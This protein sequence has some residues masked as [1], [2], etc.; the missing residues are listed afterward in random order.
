MVRQVAKASFPTRF[1]KF[2]IYAFVDDEGGEHVALL[3]CSHG[4]HPGLPVRIHSRCLTGDTLASLRCDCRDQLEASLE[5]INGKGCGILVYLD[6]EGRG[7]GLANKIKAYSLQD[8]GMDTVEANQHLGFRDDL[9]D[10]HVAAEI[11]KNLG[12]TEIDLLTNNPQKVE[13]LKLH[14][15][16]VKNR[17]PLVIKPNKYNSRY[18]ETKREK[19]HHMI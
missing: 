15:I 8:E 7:I 3:K 10:Y 9:R 12:V 1:G 19:M 11:L 5:Y 16:T 18:L 13:D 4:I 6:Q 2:T 17:M 14:G